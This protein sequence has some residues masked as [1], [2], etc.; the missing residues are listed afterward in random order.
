MVVGALGFTEEPSRNPSVLIL[1]EGQSVIPG[2][3]GNWGGG[4]TELSASL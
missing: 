4:T 1:H 2:S 3:P